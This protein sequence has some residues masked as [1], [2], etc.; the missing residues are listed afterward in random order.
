MPLEG[1]FRA[2]LLEVKT[3]R[4]TASTYPARVREQNSRRATDTRAAGLQKE[5][6]TSL[7]KANGRH[8]V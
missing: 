1:H 7:F 6:D 2:T 8:L 3:L 5:Y 4:Y